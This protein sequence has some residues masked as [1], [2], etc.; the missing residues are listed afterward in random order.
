MK[1]KDVKK[2]LDI[3]EIENYLQ[4]IFT[5]ELY[6]VGDRTIIYKS[7]LPNYHTI[8]IEIISDEKLIE[9]KLDLAGII[10]HYDIL[11]FQW[12]TRNDLGQSISSYWYRP[13]IND[14]DRDFTN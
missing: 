11:F 10:A 14:R 8:S 5:L 6:E 7:V 9:G 2:V 1:T 12:T 13:A 3:P 4:N